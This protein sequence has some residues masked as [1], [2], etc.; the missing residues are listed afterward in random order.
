MIDAIGLALH[1]HDA[2]AQHQGPVAA[3]GEGQHPDIGWL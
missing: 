1:L 3:A 2:M